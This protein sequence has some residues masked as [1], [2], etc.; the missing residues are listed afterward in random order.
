[1]VREANPHTAICAPAEQLGS[2]FDLDQFDAAVIMSH[3]LASDRQYL[4]GIAKSEIPFVGLI[5]PRHRRDRLLGEIGTSAEAL[6]ERLRGPV[7]KRIGG[8]G[9]AAIALEVAAEL[10]EYFCALND[11][12]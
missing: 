11:R 7:G 1:M 6:A 5:G 4:V 3:H 8:R 12:Q 9:P 2:D 10:Q